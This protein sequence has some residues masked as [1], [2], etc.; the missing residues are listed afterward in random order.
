MLLAE[1][2]ELNTSKLVETLKIPNPNLPF[3]NWCQIETVLSTLM[4]K[5]II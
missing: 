4:L 2:E 1:H 3:P 5:V